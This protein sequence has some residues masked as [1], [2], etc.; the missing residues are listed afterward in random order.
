MRYQRNRRKPETPKTRCTKP[1]EVRLEELIT[2]AE[3]LFL[4]QGVDSTTIDEIVELA[5]VAKGTFYHYFASKNELIEAMRRDYNTQFLGQLQKALEA[6]AEDDWPGRL[7]TW[8]RTS[9]EVYARTYRTHDIV[10]THLRHSDR[11]NL[12]K[13]AFIEQ[14]QQI[15]E[16]GTKAREWRVVRPRTIAQLIYGG[17]HSVGD[18]VIASPQTDCAAMIRETVSACLRMIGGK[19]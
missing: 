18:A 10:Y 4:A 8:V 2:A 6:V 16:G 17:V 9:I 15:L 3:Q 13:N 12:E 1:A 19:R 5:Q 7:S 11:N 14:L